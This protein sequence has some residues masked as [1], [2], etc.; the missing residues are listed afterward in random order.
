MSH[1]RGQSH[2][3]GK[4]E[5]TIVEDSYILDRGFQ[6]LLP[7][8]PELR[9]FTELESSLELK[10]FKSGARLEQDDGPI[11]MANPLRHPQNI[12]S[13][14]LGTYATLKDKFLVVKACSN[15]RS[16]IQN[17]FSRVPPARRSITSTVLASAKK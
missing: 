9:R 5:T 3:G 7:A 6:V 16:K 12:L 13:T 8:Y 2:L 11:L 15:F 10:Y 17:C 1:P 4:L 14:A